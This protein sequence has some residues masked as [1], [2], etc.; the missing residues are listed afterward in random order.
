MELIFDKNGDLKERIFAK[1]AIRQILI[2]TIFMLRF[3]RNFE[4]SCSIVLIHSHIKL[5]SR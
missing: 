1:T 3:S 2:A 4:Q 5:I